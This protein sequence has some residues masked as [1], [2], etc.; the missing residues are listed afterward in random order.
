[1]KNWG[2]VLA[3][4]VVLLPLSGGALAQSNV[5]TYTATLTGTA[6]GFATPGTLMPD[7]TV[8]V[9]LSPANNKPMFVARCDY[10]FTLDPNVDQTTTSACTGGRGLVAY[11]PSPVSTGATSATN[12]AANTAILAAR[13]DAPAGRYCGDLA[14]PDVNSHGYDDWYLPAFN[15]LLVI[16]AAYVSAGSGWFQ[17]SFYQVTATTYWS[18]SELNSTNAYY[19]YVHMDGSG[20][21]G[22]T[23]IYAIRCARKMN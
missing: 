23:G 1:M 18:S 20:A 17:S 11:Q 21:T 13:S 14:L 19:S 6:S 7:G 8:Y 3:G 16:R 10:G 2:K 15:E 9:G 4:L 22:K 12:G 5:V